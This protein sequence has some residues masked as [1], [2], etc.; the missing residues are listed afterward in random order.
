MP[1]VGPLLSINAF[2]CI[3]LLTWLIVASFHR[4]SEKAMNLA[5]YSS[6]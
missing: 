1:V 2:V 5:G 4:R 6:R 3:G